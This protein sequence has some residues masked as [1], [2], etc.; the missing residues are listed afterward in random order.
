MTDPE[1][2]TAFEAASIPR[3]QW[4]HR[5]HVRTAYLYTRAWPLDA[6][7]AK[8]RAGIKALNRSNGVQDTPTSGYHETVTVAWATIVADRVGGAEMPTFEAFAA[9]NADLFGGDFLLQFYSYERLFSIEARRT[10][11]GPDRAPLPR[12]RT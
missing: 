12:R 3:D 11:T 10:F 1:F 9:A 8:L 5:A 2:L 7:I 6:A 4:T